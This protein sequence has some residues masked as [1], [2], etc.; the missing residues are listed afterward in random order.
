MCAVIS[1]EDQTC[2]GYA[3]HWLPAAVLLSLFLKRGGG[4]FPQKG[5][6]LTFLFPVLTQVHE[7]GSLSRLLSST[8]SVFPLRLITFVL[9]VS[10]R[11]S[12]PFLEL[13]LVAGGSHI[14]SNTRDRV[15][16]ET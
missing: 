7:S 1:C 4:L 5:L 10:N 8:I 13:V 15:V 2:T 11:I 12:V 3:G 6:Y 14:S 16:P 9:L